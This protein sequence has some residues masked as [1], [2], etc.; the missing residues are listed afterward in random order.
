MN[1]VP[2]TRGIG[3]LVLAQ[4]GTFTFAQQPDSTDGNERRV[5]I[6]ITRNENG[7]TSHVT[8]EFDLN[9][10]AELHDALRELGVIDELGSIGDGE[11]VVLDLKRSCE[12]GM[13]NDMSLAL[14]MPAIVSLMDD[15]DRAYLGVHYLDVGTTEIKGKNA[16]TVKEG[17]LISH[18][19]ENTPASAAG[20]QE[21]DVIVQ[22]GKT[23]ITSGAGLAEA[24]S[25][26]EPGDEVKVVYHRGKQ[27]KEVKVKLGQREGV[28]NFDFSF[29]PDLPDME[30]WDMEAFGFNEP[31]GPRPFLGIIGGSTADGEQ[32]VRIGEVVEGSAAETMGLK[33]GDVIQ[34]M[35]DQELDN[36][37]ELAEKIAGMAPEEEVRIDFQ[38]NGTAMSATGRLGNKEAEPWPGMPPMPEVRRYR[39]QYGMGE[40]DREEMRRDMEQLRRDMDRLRRELRSDVTREMRVTID[41]SDIG[42]EDAALL[43]KKGVAG[44]DSPLELNDLHC[45]RSGQGFHLVFQVPQRADLTVDLHN[46][47]GERVYHETISGFKGNYDRL[48]DLEDQADGT[49]FLVIGQGGK[50]RTKKLVKN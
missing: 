27:K 44:L 50:T 14:S 1:T 47:Q 37:G 41:A 29:A 46:A 6:E 12:G 21:G 31:S 5:R 8:R 19:E 22:I 23:P 26:H 25:A 4:L 11:N 20:L 48:L 34:R 17:A 49:Y 38:R 42:A 45:T 7:K 36:F 43:K 39:E 33:E 13:L 10:D 40:E 9:N 3:A 30:D 28:S 15:A 24:I 2:L 35:N 32:G 16:P 18:V